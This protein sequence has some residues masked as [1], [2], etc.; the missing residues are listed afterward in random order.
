[1]PKPETRPISASGTGGA[2][3]AAGELAHRLDQAEEAA[4][5]TGLADRELAAGGVVREAAVGG[6]RVRADEVGPLALGAEA[7]ILHL[8]HADHRVVVVGLHEVDVVR[9]SRRAMA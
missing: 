5:G 7:Q 2:Q 9:P 3:R 1:M 6:E 8:H 4:G